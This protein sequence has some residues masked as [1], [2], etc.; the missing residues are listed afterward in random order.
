MMQFK[1]GAF[2]ETLLFEQFK[3]VLND[4]ATD[5]EK[6]NLKNMIEILK[7]YNK[8]SK[9]VNKENARNHHQKRQ[10]IVEDVC[11]ETLRPL[12]DAVDTLSHI[13]VESTKE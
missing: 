4:S 6:Q 3:N 10:R 13:D 9:N 2:H 1:I 7:K 11:A 5:C 12:F 8:K